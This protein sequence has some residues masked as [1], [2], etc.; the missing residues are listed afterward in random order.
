[1]RYRS[2]SRSNDP[3]I[4]AIFGLCVLIAVFVLYALSVTV[5]MIALGVL[6]VA[7]VIHWARLQPYSTANLH[8]EANRSMT[9]AAFPP[10]MEFI[11][12]FN[13]QY[14]A[15]CR[16]AH[17]APSVESVRMQLM[18]TAFEL[19]ETEDLQ[20]TPRV[21]VAEGSIEA[22]RYH[23]YLLR[24]SLKAKHPDRTLAVIN[25][26]LSRSF[27]SLTRHLPPPCV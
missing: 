24:K 19:Y 17:I 8:S 6:I 22:G 15:G 11:T 14:I 13:D 7:R 25:G 4:N 26:T 18:H 3:A 16:A 2:T 27:V 5:G 23:D 12:A 20:P 10:P 9:R 1:M 21:K